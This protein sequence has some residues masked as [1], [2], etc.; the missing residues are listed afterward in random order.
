MYLR[1]VIGFDGLLFVTR[2]TRW[3]LVDHLNLASTQTCQE[4]S[5]K[6]EVSLLYDG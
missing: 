3:K 6:R 2:A 1:G 5:C 4:H